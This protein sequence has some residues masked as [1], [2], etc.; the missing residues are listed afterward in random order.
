MDIFI[1]ELSLHEQYDTEAFKRSI[2]VFLKVVSR[3]K[4]NRSSDNLFKK[5]D[6]YH[7]RKAIFNEHFS[8]SLKKIKDRFILKEFQNIIFNK[9]NPKD[10]QDDRLHS[11]KAKYHC[12]TLNTD[13]TGYTLAEV[14]ERIISIEDKIFLLLNFEDSKF[15]GANYT[16]VIKDN[17]QKINIDCVENIRQVDAWIERKCPKTLY[18]ED[19]KKFNKTSKNQ[20]G[21]IIYKENNTGYYWYI[22]TLHKSHYEVFDNN[23]NHIAE[24]NLSGKLDRTKSDRSKNG[25]IDI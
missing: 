14:A 4:E 23:K 6:F 21:A 25:K 10:W 11:A 15:N 24:A 20:K 19:T 7:Y 12:K 13:V 22:D 1:N 16:C 18:I 9:A 5:G 8:L 17:T 3:L 2:I